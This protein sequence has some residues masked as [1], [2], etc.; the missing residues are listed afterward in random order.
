MSKFVDSLID[1]IRE[2]TENEDFDDTIGL[3]EEEILRYI[4]DAQYRLHAKIIAQHPTVFTEVEETNIV[5]DQENYAINFKAHLGNR[6]SKVEY[7]VTG[8]ADDYYKLSSAQLANR[9]TGANGH[10]SHYIRKNGEL[11]LLPTPTTAGGKLRVTYIRRPMSLDKRRLLVDNKA[12]V[13]GLQTTVTT[14]NVDSGHPFEIGHVVTI[15]LTGGGTAERTLTGVTDTS[16]SFASS[17]SSVSDNA[18]IT[19]T[20]NI[21]YSAGMS[22]TGSAVNSAAEDSGQLSKNNRVTIVDEFG[23]IKASNI[24]ISASSASSITVASSHT[25]ESGEVIPLGSNIL[26]GPYATT[27]LE[28]QPEVERYIRAYAEWKIL[29]RDSSI[30]SGEALQELSEMESDIIASYADIDGDDI[31]RIPELD[32]DFEWDDF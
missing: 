32:K 12:T 26:S 27:H 31:Y 29:K 8:D 13:D 19:G 10:P 20:G 7:S 9:D 4:N 24:L 22:I 5:A 28:F 25:L 21:T 14:I 23:N 15:P 6:I 17:V 3:T 18:T 1:E 2:A 11:L 30:D 16:I